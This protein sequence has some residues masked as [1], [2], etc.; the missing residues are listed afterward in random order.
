MKKNLMMLVAAMM[1]S[2]VCQA[3]E[4]T[5]PATLDERATLVKIFEALNGQ[6]WSERDKKGWCTDAAL[7]EWNGVTVNN[8]GKVVRLKLPLSNVKGVLPA[9]IQN[10]SSLTYLE[11]RFFNL[12]TEFKNP[13]PAC[14]FQMPTLENLKLSVYTDK[15]E[16]YI[17][18]PQNFNLPN[19]KYLILSNVV[20]DFHQLAT[21]ANL[22]QITISSSTPD[23]PDEIGKCSKLGLIYW[24]NNKTPTKP[25]TAEL[26]KLTQLSKLEIYNK[27]PFEEKIPDFIW[28]ISSLKLLVLKNV[29]SNH[30]ELDAKKVAQL[31]SIE[32]LRLMNDGITNLPEGL[33]AIPTL[34]YL[35]LSGNAIKGK[36]PASIGNSNL[37]SLD[38]EGNA[39]LTGKIPDSM[40]NLKDLYSLDLRKTG[41]E[42]KIPKSVQELP[43]FS[44]F[45]ERIF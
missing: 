28:N 29:A 42:Q 36:I 2:I 17:Q 26:A 39:E 7:G 22:E 18:L 19:L 5:A 31:P 11:I 34:K 14:V 8:E 37:Q 9:E 43:R 1:L 16:Q 38:L 4:P 30:G 40:G 3:T 41:I 32:N 25:L 35:T 45:G 12:K 20:G 10:L 6:N 21:C 24:E 15:E 13:V 23:I 33:F 44:S 27:T